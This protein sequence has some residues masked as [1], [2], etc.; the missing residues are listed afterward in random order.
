[1]TQ[2]NAM[3]AGGAPVAAATLRMAS[4]AFQVRSEFS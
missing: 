3:S 1:M 2:L 4:T